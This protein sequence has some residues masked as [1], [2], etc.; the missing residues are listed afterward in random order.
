MTLNTSSKSIVVKN[1]KS[2]E[3]S[4]HG[5]KLQC[6]LVMEVAYMLSWW[7]ALMVENHMLGN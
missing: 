2:V 6:N 5:A 1:T 7:L 3:P 4:A